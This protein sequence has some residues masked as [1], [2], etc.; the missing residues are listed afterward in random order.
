MRKVHRQ[1]FCHFDMNHKITQL[2]QGREIP[3]DN[4]TAFNDN[5]LITYQMRIDGISGAIY[6]KLVPAP[7]CLTP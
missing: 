5:F 2:K 3:N 1:G 6:K 4:C 7:Y